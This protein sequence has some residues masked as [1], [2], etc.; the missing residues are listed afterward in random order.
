MLQIGNLLLLLWP[1]MKCLVL[2]CGTVW[3]EIISGHHWMPALTKLT[4]IMVETW[5][6]FLVCFA[7]SASVCS[8]AHIEML[9]NSIFLMCWLRLYHELIQISLTSFLIYMY[10]SPST[11]MAAPILMFFIILYEVLVDI[12]KCFW[13][14]CWPYQARLDKGWYLRRENCSTMVKFDT[15]TLVSRWTGIHINLGLQ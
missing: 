6:N 15:G 9:Q 1:I 3:F 12:A 14:Y 11:V 13:A 2:V 8:T 10:H 4:L 7:W 5:W